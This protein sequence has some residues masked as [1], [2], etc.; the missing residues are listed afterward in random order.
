MI[1]LLATKILEGAVAI[2]KEIL[3]AR[4]KAANDELAKGKR[5]KLSVRVDFTAEVLSTRL[6]THIRDIEGWSKHSSF[7]DLLKKKD[8]GEI[9]VS[10]ETYVMPV[11]THMSDTERKNKK[12]LQAAL[13]SLDTHCVILGQPGAGKTT[14]LQKLC[15]D[16]FKNGKVLLNYNFPILVRLREIK[17]SNSVCPICDHLSEILGLTISTSAIEVDQK[18]YHDEIGYWKR[19]AIIAHL[20]A[21]HISLLIDGLDEIASAEMRANAVDEIRMLSVGLQNSR[22]FLTCRSA[23]F[24]YEVQKM[25]KLEIAPLTELQIFEFA[26][27]WLDDQTK[28]DKFLAQVRVS[29]FFDTAIRPLTL[30][31]LCA[32]FE[33][34]GG[35]PNEPRSVYKKVVNLLLEEWDAQ[36]SVQRTTA[37]SNFTRDRKFDFLCAL[38]YQ[39]TVMERATQ[40]DHSLL[41]LVY[42]RICTRFQL[43]PDEARA[44]A[45]ELESHSGLLLEASYGKYEFAHKSVQ[46]YLTAEYIVRLASPDSISDRLLEIPSELAIAITLSSD[47]ANYLGH[48]TINTLLPKDVSKEF[49]KALLD[50]LEIERPEFAP[51]EIAVLGAAALITKLGP[52]PQLISLFKPIFTLGFDKILNRYYAA[53]FDKSDSIRYLTP[54]NVTSGILPAYLLV[55]K[56]FFT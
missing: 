50:R 14:S 45:R 30:A 32:I 35:I 5:S 19:D 43:P 25:Q 52:A 24:S 6:Q 15:V 11:R 20:D 31:H 56:I 21:L 41:A 40:F 33:R 26:H 7:F 2:A 51:S 16:F 48:L 55:P 47:P 44:V 42:R 13:I 34:I 17:T 49:L 36:R 39:L 9:Y 38:C 22:L 8:I 1:E 29:P 54:Q 10:L 4:L 23:D 53:S 12:P 28:A 46:E 3:G 37:Y 27:A 18:K